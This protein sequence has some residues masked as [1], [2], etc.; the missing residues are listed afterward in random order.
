M[1]PTPLTP[2][3]LDAIADEHEVLADLYEGILSALEGGEDQLSCAALLDELV[4]KLAEHFRHE[5][6]G[7]YYSHVLEIAPWRAA[8][9]KELERQHADLYKSVARVAQ[10]ARHGG[11][12]GAVVGRD[13][14]GLHRI[15]ASLRRARVQ[16]KTPDSG[17]LSPGRRCGRLTFVR[18]RRHGQLNT[19]TI[20]GRAKPCFRRLS[21]TRFGP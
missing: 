6:R 13:S 10:G 4:E 9:V 18:L 16:G 2:E 17:N 15:S 21:N 3:A 7:G 1:K 19:L 20:E 14:Q 12:F 8:A 11:W 5:E